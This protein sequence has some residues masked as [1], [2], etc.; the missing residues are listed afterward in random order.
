MGS[1]LVRTGVIARA[2]VRHGSPKRPRDRIQKVTGRKEQNAA[3]VTVY[4][5]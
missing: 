1:A 4:D 5:V 3:L 2:D